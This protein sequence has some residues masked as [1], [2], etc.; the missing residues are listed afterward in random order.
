MIRFWILQ[1]ILIATMVGCEGTGVSG[2][3]AFTIDQ[4]GVVITYEREAGSETGSVS[5]NPSEITIPEIHARPIVVGERETIGPDGSVTTEPSISFIFSSEGISAAS[6]WL[7][8]AE[9]AASLLE[10]PIIIASIL[11]V[12]GVVLV[13]A[14]PLKKLGFAVGVGG[15]T[16]GVLA[17]L[18]IQYST[19]IL[20]SIAILVVAAIIYGI[21]YIRRQDGTVGDVVESI[22]VM[23]DRY[24][25][26]EDKEDAFNS[27]SG[28]VVKLQSKG[29]RKIVREKREKLG[30]KRRF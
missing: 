6:A 17:Y 12:L 23:K 21:F 8:S 9:I 22:E 29:T 30:I 25:T 11:V 3:D 1:L 14:T 15:A 27:S 18:L 24:M 5:G 4:N 2:R 16:L 7:S 13:I 26:D 19:V 10:W 28:S 20:I